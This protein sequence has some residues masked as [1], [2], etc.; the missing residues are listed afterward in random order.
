LTS[1]AAHLPTEFKSS[2]SGKSEAKSSGLYY[3]IKAE[4]KAR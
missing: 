1:G 2:N 4:A 3:L